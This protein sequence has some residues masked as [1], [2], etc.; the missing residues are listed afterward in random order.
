MDGAGATCWF[1]FDR[2]SKG[3]YRI[4]DVVVGDHNVQICVSPTGRSVQI[5]VDGEKVT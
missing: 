5:H 1:T 4:M 2:G 3:V